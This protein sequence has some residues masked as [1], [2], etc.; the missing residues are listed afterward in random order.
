MKC[1]YCAEDIKDEAVVCRY[2]QHDFSLVKPLLARLISLE[3]DV[4]TL[5]SAVEPASTEAIS[6]AAFAAG[7]AVILGVILTSGYFLITGQQEDPANLPYVFA[8]VV[9]PVALG[10]LVGVASK[11]RSARAALI[12][13]FA[14]GILNFL[15]IWLMLGSVPGAVFQKPLAF[16]TLAVGQSLTFATFNLLGNSLRSGWP[17]IKRTRNRTGDFRSGAK[18][19]NE[20]LSLAVDFVKSVTFLGLTIGSAYKWLWG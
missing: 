3:E 14:L 6:V 19:I 2:C 5:G 20:N 17:P 16:T 12:A 8:I 10:L 15:L 11:R 9:P 13:G 1:P 4:E 7:I 18:R